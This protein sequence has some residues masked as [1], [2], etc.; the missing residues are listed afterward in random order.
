LPSPRSAELTCITTRPC[1]D[2]ARTIAQP[3]GTRYAESVAVA[4]SADR[5]DDDD[6]DASPE[7]GH[8]TS[9]AHIRNPRP[10]RSKPIS[11]LPGR[12]SGSTLT[13]TL[14]CSRTSP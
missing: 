5:P 2:L 6:G 9:Q 4:L 10:K 11:R 12:W 1:A 3:R 8:N 7:V 14:R 13:I